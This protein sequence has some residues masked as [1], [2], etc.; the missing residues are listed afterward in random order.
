[1]RVRWVSLNVALSDD[2]LLLDYRALV[3]GP[4]SS[5]LSSRKPSSKLL[6]H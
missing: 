2:A 1:M 4:V 5:S 6:G 3:A